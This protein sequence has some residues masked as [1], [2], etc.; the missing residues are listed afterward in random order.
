MWLD[1]AL[2][3]SKQI[4]LSMWQLSF[5][6]IFA[7]WYSYGVQQVAISVLVR[8]DAPFDKHQ[9]NVFCLRSATPSRTQT[10]STHLGNDAQIAQCDGYQGQ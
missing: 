4:K 8:G 9:K 10:V 5:S 1:K 6:P 2:L 3:A 7:Q